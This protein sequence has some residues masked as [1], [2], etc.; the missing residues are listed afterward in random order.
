MENI[1]TL[2]SKTNFQ[3][4]PNAEVNQIHIHKIHCN[5]LLFNYK[6]KGNIMIPMNL[7]TKQKQNHREYKL[8]FT[9]REKM[10]GTNSSWHSQI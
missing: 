1:A 6:T 4:S 10:R 7:F 3:Q 5:V 9:N 8:T 2:T